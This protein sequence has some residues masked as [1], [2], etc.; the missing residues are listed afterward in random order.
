I[1]HFDDLPRHGCCVRDLRFWAR[2]CIKD[3]HGLKYN[4]PPPLDLAAHRV[5]ILS[6]SPPQASPSSVD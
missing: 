5:S 6:W 1:D 3:V 2:H 4:S